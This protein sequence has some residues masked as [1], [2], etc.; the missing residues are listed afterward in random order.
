MIQWI[1]KYEPKS[2]SEIKGQDEAVEYL[3][4]FIKNPKKSRKKAV[5][6]YGPS[7]NGKT[8]S[9]YALAKELDLELIE[10]NASDFRNK[11]KIDSS[12][13]EASKQMSLFGKRKLILVDEVD[14]LSGHEDRG[15]VQAINKVI[16]ESRFPVILTCNDAYD[17]KLSSIRKNC[18]MVEFQQLDHNIIYGVIMNIC[19]KENI[20]Y[21]E[22]ALKSLARRESGDLRGAIT[23]L[24]LL[25]A[26]TNKIS[27]DELDQLGDRMKTESI[28]QALVKVFKTTDPNIALTAFDN[29]D[30]EQDKLFLWLDENLPDEY[31]NPEDLARAY[32][33]LS[34]A[35]VF[36]RRI[37]RWQHWRFMV[38][39]NAYLTAGIATAKDEKYKKFVKYKPTGRLLKI[40]WANQ[41][42]MKRKAI[43][44]KIADKTHTSQKRVYKDVFPYFKAMFKEDND[45]AKK[46][47]EQFGLSEDEAEWIKK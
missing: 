13:G 28:L 34:R 15:G 32:D 43:C 9:V 44:Q 7:G 36:R 35:D 26:G 40:W 41:K 16:E 31:E 38:Y 5:I 21:D 18:E 25:S 4:E 3:K 30:E 45:L 47:T 27:D 29:V 6:L 37:K 1:K 10:V 19:K 2:L 14:G 11:D 39:I 42:N 8:S 20:D 17:E 24:Q 23:D 33:M 46:F 12:I 22:T